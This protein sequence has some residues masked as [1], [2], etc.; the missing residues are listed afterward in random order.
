MLKN[1]LYSVNEAGVDEAGRGCLCGSVFAAAVILPEGFSHP[2]L[3]DSKKMSNKNRYLLREVIEREAVA[4]AVAEVSAQEIDRIN[5]LNASFR[6][7]NLAIAKLQTTPSHLLIDG[8]RFK[9]ESDITFDCIIGGDALYASIAAASV[10]A[11]T[12][13]DDYMLRLHDEF[14]EYG[15]A[16]NM[17][18]PTAEHRR[19]IAAH[20]IT[21]HHRMTFGDCQPKLF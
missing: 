17:G 5:I 8:N 14:P 11:K 3:N 10:L 4:Y 15:W 19:A 2:L 12:Y 1:S 21:A 18:Y 16:R 13:R 9:N 6:A 20:G 7:M